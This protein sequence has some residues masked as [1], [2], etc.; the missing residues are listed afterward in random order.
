MR[1]SPWSMSPDLRAPIVG[2]YLAKATPWGELVAVV[3]ETTSTNDEMLRFGEGEA[4][5]GT[6]LFAETQSAGRGQ[7]G[8]PWASAEGLGLWFSILLRMEINDGVIP[9]LSRFA[10]VAIVDTL[11][12]LGV[13]P[14]GIKAPNDVLIGELKVAGILV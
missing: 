6:I 7:F 14:V 2:S 9:A 12:G 10:A 11:R 5:S 3:G 13:N 8:R 4:S 1:T